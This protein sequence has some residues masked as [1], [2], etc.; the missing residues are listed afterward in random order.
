M[1]CRRR[2]ASWFFAAAQNIAAKDCLMSYPPTVRHQN[3][4]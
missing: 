3:V 1:F 2:D 4:F